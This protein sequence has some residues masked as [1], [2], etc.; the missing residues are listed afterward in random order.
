MVGWP[1]HVKYY[2]AY[3]EHRLEPDILCGVESSLAASCPQPC[4][5]PE[6]MW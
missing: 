4:S 1:D 3:Q 5:F 2:E 6:F